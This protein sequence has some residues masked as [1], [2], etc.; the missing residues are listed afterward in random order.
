[1][2]TG[3]SAIDRIT[4]ALERLRTWETEAEL[5]APFVEAFQRAA[6]SRPFPESVALANA[7]ILG[8]VLLPIVQ[9]SPGGNAVTRDTVAATI[10][11][12]GSKDNVVPA[13]ATASVNARLLPATDPEE[14][15][16]RL[17]DRIADPTI[18]IKA[19]GWPALAQISPTDTDTF[20]AIEKALRYV[21]PTVI[22]VPSQTP[23]TMDARFFSEAGVTSYRIHPF[24]MSPDERRRLHAVDERIS[25]EN[26]HRGVRFY[27]ALAQLQ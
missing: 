19:R 11:H 18:E 27:W 13:V 20:R 21:E 15:L 1:M 16:A 10:V 14:F 6:G 8:P 4:A 5:P 12:S 25:L 22:P 24:I 23:G 2:P 7:D 17:T 3:R 26:L 9:K